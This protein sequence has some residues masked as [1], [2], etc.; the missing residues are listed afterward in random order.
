MSASINDL[1][2]ALGGRR[3]GRGWLCRCP[4]HEDRHP[5]LALTERD[6]RVLFRCWSGCSQDE[7]IAALWQRGLWRGREVIPR[8]ARPDSSGESA[9]RDPLK[10]WRRAAP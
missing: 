1:A 6:G 4:A 3:N 9:R 10:T 5:S 8:R 2:L 7:V